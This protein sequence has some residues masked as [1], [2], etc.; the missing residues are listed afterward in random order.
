MPLKAN[1]KI[2]TLKHFG[3]TGPIDVDKSGYRH[4]PIF[5]LKASAPAL[6]WLGWLGLLVITRAQYNVTW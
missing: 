1:S 6:K 4:L 2:M 5:I 3:N